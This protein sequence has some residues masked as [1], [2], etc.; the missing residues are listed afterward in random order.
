M[1][2]TRIGGKEF[3]RMWEGGRSRQEIAN[4]FNCS[5][6]HV[7]TVARREKLPLKRAAGPKKWSNTERDYLVTQ[8]RKGK[9]FR[10]IADEM[11]RSVSSVERK[12]CTL[13]L[14]KPGEHI[15]APTTGIK[16]LET[17]FFPPPWDTNMD[18]RLFRICRR[19]HHKTGGIYPAICR[20]ADKHNL[21]IDAVQSRWHRIGRIVSGGYHQ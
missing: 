16:R 11:N 19:S 2:S 8:H 13:C 20:F 4:R 5:L 10:E 21:T 12:A 7:S 14:S 3:R 9:N 18:E 6:N 1:S 15:S 17:T